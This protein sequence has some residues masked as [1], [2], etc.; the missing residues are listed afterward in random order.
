MELYL[1]SYTYRSLDGA[2]C[3]HMQV[4]GES[5]GQVPTPTRDKLCNCKG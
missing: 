4:A 3:K 5:T 2:P 1:S